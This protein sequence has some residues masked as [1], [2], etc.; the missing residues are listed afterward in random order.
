MR[1]EQDGRWLGRP[2][3]R[4]VALMANTTSLV[5]SAA[6]PAFVLARVCAA[7]PG[8][9]AAFVPGATVS[10]LDSWWGSLLLRR[11]ISTR[12]VEGGVPGRAT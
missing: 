12:V 2:P 7:D 9:V 3:G 5:R 4:A 6:T 11:Q 10:E 8:G 1:G